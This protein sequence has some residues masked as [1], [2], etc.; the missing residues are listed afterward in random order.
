MHT[1]AIE[2]TGTGVAWKAFKEAFPVTLP[3]LAGLDVYKR[4]GSDICHIFSGWTGREE[5]ER[6]G[7]GKWNPSFTAHFLQSK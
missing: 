7:M 1:D 5:T 2:S 3:I 6:T 4:Q